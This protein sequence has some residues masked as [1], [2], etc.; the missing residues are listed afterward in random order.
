MPLRMSRIVTLVLL[1]LVFA[2]AGC[3]AVPEESTPNILTDG[4]GDSGFPD[5]GGFAEIIDIAADE[6]TFDVDA[7]ADVE[8]TGGWGW[9]CEDDDE[10]QSGLCVPFP[11][12]RACSM[13]CVEQCPEEAECV[14]EPW[15]YMEMV[16][17]VPLHTLLCAPC[18]DDSDCGGGWTTM[19]RCVSY[20]D[21][22]S[23][24]G[25]FCSDEKPCPEGYSCTDV[26]E[27]EE[28]N[29]YSLQCVLDEGECAC[30]FWGVEEKAQ[31]TCYSPAN[32]IGTC[33]G[34]RACSEEGLS[35]CD[36]PPAAAEECNGEDDDCDG[37][38]DEDLGDTI[39]G[40]GICEH[41]QPDCDAGVAVE[42]DPLAGMEEETCD[43]LDNDCN[44]EIDDLAPVTC[45]LGLCEHEIVPCAE[46]L[47]VECNPMEGAAEEACDGLD[48]DCDGDVDEELPP[49]TCGDG[50]CANEVPACLEGVPGECLP[51]DVA[52]EE[53]CDG[54]DNNCD[55]TVDDGFDDT[56]LDLLADCVDD[57]DDNDTVPDDD[58]NCPL[59]ANKKQI[60]KD[61]DGFGD[62]C[63]LGCWLSEEDGWESDCD[64]LPDSQDNC[65]DDANPLQVDTDDDG[66]GDACDDD[67]DDDDVKDIFDNCPLKANPDQTDTDDDNIGDECDTDDDNDGKT[68][69][70]DNCVLVANAGQEDFDFDD[71]GDACDLDDDNDGDPDETDCEPKQPK[72]SSIHAEV[73]NNFDDN[74]DGVVDE[75][76]AQKCQVFY[77]D[78][79]EDSYGIE[80]DSKCLCVAAEFYTAKDIGDC[81]PEDP[82][83]YPGAVEIC[84]GLDDNCDDQTDEG[85]ADL[86]LNG[87]ADCL[88][89]DDDGDGVDDVIDNCP[90]VPNENQENNDGDDFGDICDDDDDNDGVIDDQDCEPF[91]ELQY[92]G[93]D[94]TCDGLDNNCNGEVD[95]ELGS[96]TCGLGECLH[97]VQNC[98]G[99]VTQV[100]DPLEGKTDDLCDGHD[101]DCDG[102][103]DEDLGTTTCGLGECL[104]TVEN[105][106]E[107]QEQQCD[108][109][110]GAADEICDLLDNDCDGPH[111]EELGSTTCGLGVCEHTVENCIEGVPQQCDA[112]AGASDETCDSLD[113]DCNGEKDDGLGTTT[114]GLGVCE[115]TIQNCQ[116]GQ[117]Q[118]CDPLE[119]AGDEVC[120]GL[121]NNCDGD[122]DEGFPDFDLDDTPDCLDEDDDNDGSLDGVDCDDNDIAV[123]PGADE[124]CDEKDNDCNGAV[125][126]GCPGVVSGTDCL[127]IHDTYPAFT[128]GLYTI[129]ADGDGNEVPVE[130]YCDMT[131]DGGGWTR[132]ANVK[133]EESGCPG[134][135]VL[136]NIPLVCTR[137]FGSSGCRSAT[138]DVFGLEFTEVRGYV[139]AYQFYSM[140]AFHTNSPYGLDGAYV[141]GVSITYDIP[142]KHVWSYA[143]GLSENYNYGNHN[144]PCAVYKGGVP[145]FVGTDYYCESGNSGPYENTWYTGDP[146]F[147]GN[148]CP[149]GNTCC[150]ND[151][152]PW[153]HK[154]LSLPQTDDLEARLCSDQAPSSEDVGIYRMELYVR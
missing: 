66:L 102:F 132:V 36:A 63:D 19:S 141:D 135:W 152:L 112:M 104:H 76:G 44:G 8:T 59:I 67:D 61:G 87:V 2:L 153:F 52:G 116:G 51:L 79:D 136:T 110:E 106:L 88:D 57:D 142:R 55:G 70:K 90:A 83:A 99:A 154:T 24:C 22:G 6:L 117:E 123:Y 43:G 140:V 41:A 92:P 118:Q 39:C 72:V 21:A 32:E 82:L 30:P 128:T 46:I 54:L 98:V 26:D 103:V 124:I 71:I 93:L 14:W 60:D 143:V 114:C 11:D 120:D 101:N 113:N 147:D 89:D 107:G 33:A 105:C 37:L 149:A 148:G 84:N 16:A 91:N 62:V 146:L 49:L 126:E 119:D 18:T 121:D 115:H 15:G 38:V 53:I 10:C 138:F 40:L 68:D 150:N 28:D 34:A 130:V 5:V 20:G 111:D 145:S 96:T 58:D 139:R 29:D 86:D 131:S 47:P 74:C 45:G 27:G 129:D 9:P 109:L 73:C 108:P 80:E 95:E 77:L 125:D 50:L 1:V 12:G 100:C 7:R 3:P 48:N 25:A 122:T 42:C 56:D 23:F 127:D 78:V 65:P 151:S 31:T 75:E 4:G 137:L 133:P 144:C 85:F 81:L 13:S 94:E 69:A 17:C 134:S 35:D 97:T 64:S